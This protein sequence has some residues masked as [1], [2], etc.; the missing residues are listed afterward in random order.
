MGL[1][2]GCYFFGSFS[3]GASEGAALG[4]SPST[5]LSGHTL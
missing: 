5:V 3:L 1:R 4:S 2:D